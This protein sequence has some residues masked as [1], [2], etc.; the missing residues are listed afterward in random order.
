MLLEDFLNWLLS[1]FVSIY[2]IYF[3]KCVSQIV[4]FQG[5]GGGGGGE[6]KRGGG[7]REEGRGVGGRGKRDGGGGRLC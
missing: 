2:Y 6:G 3:L 5:W 7:K 1:I 4:F